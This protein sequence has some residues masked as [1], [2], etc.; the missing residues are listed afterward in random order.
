MAVTRIITVVG[1]GT[2]V[3]ATLLTGPPSVA[4][5]Q[6]VRISVS[7]SGTQGNSPSGPAVLARNALKVAFVSAA[8]NLVPG[9]TNNSFD[10]F[11][12]DLTTNVTTRVSVAPDGTQR[13]GDSGTPSS[14]DPWL[15]GRPAST[16]NFD[17][18][19]DAR[20][21]VFTSS[22]ALVAD[23]TN[24]C[25]P[26]LNTS[27]TSCPD[28]YVR[29]LQTNFTFR[30]NIGPGG[31]QAN[32]PSRHPR[33]QGVGVYFVSDASN[34]VPNDTNGVADVF[35]WNILD[36]R[37][38]LVSTTSAG[39]FG[40]RASEKMAVRG[41]PT[42][43]SA[44]DNFDTEPDPVPCYGGAPCERA[45]TY[46]IYRRRTIRI[47]MPPLDTGTSSNP[48][49]VVVTGVDVAHPGPSPATL[50]LRCRLR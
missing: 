33:L 41:R 6:P 49:R 26:P 15:G 31:V 30:V 40:N 18:D 50:G 37:L 46:D 20:F 10:V 21:V 19:D 29:D 48:V 12:R 43:I 4:A 25:I 28:I 3:G 27:P 8:S 35:F 17:I 39:G 36:G 23:D 16:V 9:D 7:S 22:A 38:S 5:Q 47:P 11:V 13:P 32:G 42:W 14:G 44:A 2:I 34:L 45:F 24:Q 1:A